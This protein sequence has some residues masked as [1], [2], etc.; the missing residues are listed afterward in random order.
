VQEVFARAWSNRA[1]FHGAS[2][3]TTWLTRIAINEFSTRLR[4]KRRWSRIAGHLLSRPPSGPRDPRQVLAAGEA[5]ALAADCLSRLPA[6]QREAFVLRYLED[7]SCAET[8]EI[9]G[10][11]ENVVRARAFSARKKLRSMLGDV[12]R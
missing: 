6:R 3:V 9:L 10:V 4:G 7:L 8:A 11:S 2:K 12:E 1:R 5:H